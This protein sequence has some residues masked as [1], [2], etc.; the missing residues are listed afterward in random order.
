MS[1]RASGGTHAV[2]SWCMKTQHLCKQVLRFAVPGYAVFVRHLFLL[3]THSSMRQL[4]PA[5]I[6]ASASSKL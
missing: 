4:S 1:E 5:V 2:R 3:I 6:S